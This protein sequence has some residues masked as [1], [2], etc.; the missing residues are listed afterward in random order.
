MIYQRLD[1]NLYSDVNQ[2]PW[3]CQHPDRGIEMEIESETDIDTISATGQVLI[4]FLTND[5]F[6]FVESNA[7]RKLP[8]TQ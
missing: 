7:T 3:Q 8:N 2:Q 6:V 5:Q 4:I 1:T